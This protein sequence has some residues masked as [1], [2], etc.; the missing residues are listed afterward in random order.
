MPTIYVPVNVP[1]IERPVSWLIQLGNMYM[2]G[3]RDYHRA[4]QGIARVNPDYEP[5]SAKDKFREVGAS[6]LEHILSKHGLP[7]ELLSATLEFRKFLAVSTS[8]RCAWDD[9]DVNNLLQEK[10]Q[11]VRNYLLDMVGEH[12]GRC[13]EEERK[14]VEARLGISQGDDMTPL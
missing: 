11:Q 4:R 9:P 14:K 3:L 12:F 8:I 10:Y 13:Q 2:D 7:F 1:T 6:M 5:N